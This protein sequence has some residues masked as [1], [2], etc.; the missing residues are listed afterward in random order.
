MKYISTRGQA[1]EL[2]FDDVVLTGLAR[3]GGLYVPKVW[4][5]FSP[6]EIRSWKDLTYAELAAKVMAPF[7]EGCLSEQDLSALTRDTYASF[8]HADVA[9]LVKLADGE[10][11]LELFHGP[12]LA[13]KDYA[14]QFLGR[15]FDHI[16]KKRGQSITIA[17]ATS[18]D[19]GSAAI[20]ACRDRDAIEIFILHPEGKVSEVQRRQMTTVMSDNVHNIA[21]KGTFDD[22]QNTIKALFDD[23]AF[24]DKVDL[25]AVNSINWARILGQIVYYFWAALKVGD[26]TQKVSF[27]VPTGNFGNV[28]AGFA[29]RQM[30]LAVEQLVI[31]SN[32]NDILIRFLESGRM[33]TRGVVHTISPSMD[34][35]ISSNFE[36]LLFELS[37][38]DGKK[39]S[40]IMQGFKE[41]GNYA[42]DANFMDNLKSI[43]EGAR[44]DD[45]ATRDLIRTTYE[46]NKIL[47]DPHSAIGLG[48]ARACN[49]KA[50]PMVVLATA[51]AAK[52]PDAVKEASGQHPDLPAHLSDLL[53]RPERSETLANDLAGVKAYLESTL[54]ARGKL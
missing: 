11:M 17:G 22:C 13:F 12:T 38:R 52:F 43:F 36:R 30:G 3:D 39:V 53:E 41:S 46:Q 6:E 16:L 25:S 20:E 14:L 4:P 35:E 37:G 15:L 9:P 44:F 10:Y 21:L 50:A 29:A 7:V 19:T 24:R 54:T 8:D 2:D 47:L 34:I 5:E 51:H 23:E 1:P 32:S 48:A 31:G 42:V 28:F 27:A 45:D 40:A 26:G 33:E 49:N 18:G